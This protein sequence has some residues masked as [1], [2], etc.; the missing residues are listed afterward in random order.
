MSVSDSFTFAVNGDVC[1][2]ITASHLPLDKLHLLLD[3]TYK[4][5]APIACIAES[6]GN[7]DYAY[8]IAQSGDS[9][10]VI[11]LLQILGATETGWNLSD[12]IIFSPRPSKTRPPALARAIS[13]ARLVAHK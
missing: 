9:I 12:G 6:I 11:R 7:T 10:D 2:I 8:T 3:F 4:A 1:E 13:M 5:Y